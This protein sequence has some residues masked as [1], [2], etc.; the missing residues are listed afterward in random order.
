MLSD[1]SVVVFAQ[2]QRGVQG[3]VAFTF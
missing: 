2:S 1:G 3:G